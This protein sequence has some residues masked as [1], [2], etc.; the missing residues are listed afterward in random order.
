M[1]GR[2]RLD[3]K[4]RRCSD[5][6]FKSSEHLRVRVWVRKATKYT[7]NFVYIYEYHYVYYLGNPGNSCNQPILDWLV[8]TLYDSRYLDMISI[9]AGII[10]TYLCSHSEQ[11]ISPGYT[12]SHYPDILAYGT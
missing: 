1:R 4:A 3:C 9:N 12:L 11:V 2:L 5:Y 7:F 10:N 6:Q 8:A